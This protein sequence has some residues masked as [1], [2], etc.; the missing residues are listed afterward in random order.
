MVRTRLNLSSRAMQLSLA[1]KA[2]GG[3]ALVVSTG[4]I[5]ARVENLTPCV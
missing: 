3:R 1:L 4:P 2:A 5:P